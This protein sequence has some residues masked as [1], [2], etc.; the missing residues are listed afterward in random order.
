M[1]V[2]GG[3]LTDAVSGANPIKRDLTRWIAQRMDHIVA[4][5][6]YIEKDCIEVLEGTGSIMVSPNDPVELRKTFV[7]ILDLD[8]KEREII[9]RKGRERE[10]SFRW[11]NRTNNMIQLFEDVRA[12]RF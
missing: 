2:H 7:Q 6:P 4:V 9:I 8:P 1:S 11:E 12:S 3:S 10:R 5:N